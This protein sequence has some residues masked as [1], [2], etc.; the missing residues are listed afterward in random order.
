M[1]FFRSCLKLYKKSQTIGYQFVLFNDNL[2][3]CDYKPISKKMYALFE[4]L[5]AHGM[6]VRTRKR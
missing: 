1:K 3:L 2:Y 6:L 5:S 4:L